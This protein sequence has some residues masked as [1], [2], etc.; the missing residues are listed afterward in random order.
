MA[1]YKTVLTPHLEIAYHEHGSPTGWPVILSHGFPYSPVSFDTVVPILTLQGARVIVPYLRGFAP[2]RFLSQDTT[3]TGITTQSNQQAALGSDL[4]DLL[5]ALGI[6]KAILGGFDWGGVASCVVAALWPERVAGLVSYAGYDIYNVANARDEPCTPELEAVMWYQHLFQS[7]R[8]R[9]CL[10]KDRKA[11]CKLLWKQWSPTWDFD[12]EVF[13]RVAVSWEGEEWVDVVISIYRHAFGNLEGEE[14]LEGLERRLEL[15][16]RIEVPT[17]TIDGMRDPLKPGGSESHGEMFAGRH[18]RRVV[19][20]G[21]AMP[22]ERPEEFA[23][24]VLDV[25]EWIS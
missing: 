15:K 2:T 21:H 13:E 16:P 12:E 7:E 9:K 19:D 23:R 3:S 4:L 11:F 6:E 1:S 18:K 10:A 25:H 22:V 14:R 20:C 5:D 24:A 8:G 17:V